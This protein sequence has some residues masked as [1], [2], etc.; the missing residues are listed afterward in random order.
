MSDNMVKSLNVESLWILTPIRLKEKP[1]M[2]SSPYMYVFCDWLQLRSVILF[3]WHSPGSCYIW[4]GLYSVIWIHG[5]AQCSSLSSASPLSKIFFPL[6]F[7]QNLYI[8]ILICL[9]FFKENCL[10]VNVLSHLLNYS[11]FSSTI[12]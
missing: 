1:F 6:V 5:Q 3:W 4:D 2:T 12:L 9:L 10:L 11:M 8:S 7:C